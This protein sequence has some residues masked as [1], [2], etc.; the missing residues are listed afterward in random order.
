MENI[1]YSLDE[2]IP[3]VIE[4]IHALNH[5]I[6]DPF[7]VLVAGGTASGK[8]S[9]VAEKIHGSFDNSIIVSM[10][11]YYKGHK[12]MD[13]Q[14]ALGNELN[15]DQPEALDLDLFY[16]HLSELKQRKTVFSP[17]YDFQTDPVYDAIEIKSAEIIIVEGLFALDDK[18]SSL[19][20]LNVFVDIG[21][22]GQIMRR[23]FRDIK[24]TGEKPQ[25]ILDY[26]LETVEPMHMKY[27]FPSKKNANVVIS[28]AYN[29]DVEADNSGVIE[30]NFKLALLD[31]DMQKLE[32]SVYKL[33]GTYLGSVEHNDRYFNPS[34]RVLS[35]TDEVIKIR[36]IFPDKL[37]LSYKGPQKESYVGDERFVM[38][39][40][41]DEDSY[42]LFKT[43]YSDSIK[44]LSKTRKNYF[45]GG[46]LISVDTFKN[47]K[48]FLDCK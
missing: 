2:G 43:V 37:L 46:V 17:E 23:I 14:K 32:D 39:F 7:V 34:D 15:W 27:I 41:I 30:S 20:N 40:F 28:N 36:K 33:G 10:D 29:P 44:E 35:D 19:G 4:L 8:T 12:F 1:T 25:D 11:N 42:Q 26:F 48:I 45:L 18:L 24:R 22:H 21:A 13:E 38:R 31:L 16:K 5:D 9:R 47:G 6:D 3:K